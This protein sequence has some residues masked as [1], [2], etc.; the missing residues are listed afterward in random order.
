MRR[1]SGVDSAFIYGETPTWHMH[2][3]S[4]II[5]D[6][7]DMEDGFDVERLK[8]QLVERLPQ[9][10]Q[11]RWKLVEVPFHLDRPGWIEDADF[12]ID[13]HVR[14]I[15]VP[16]PG[17]SD[18]L[19]RLVGDLASYQ[20]DRSRPLWELWVIEGV[21]DGMVAIFAKI[22]HAII[23]GASG[24]GLS[25]ILLDLEPDPP[26]RDLVERGNVGTH[27]PHPLDLMARGMLSF[28]V[29]PWRFGRLAGQLVRQGIEVARAAS[30]PERTLPPM[31]I[32]T[33]RTPLN[34][35]I[36]PHRRFATSTVP[37]DD[38]KAMKNAFGVK[39]NDVVLEL[40]AAA[41]RRWLIDQDELPDDPLIAQVP[42]SLRSEGDDE[43]GTKVGA[44]FTSLATDIED[45]GERLL[46]IHAATQSAKE[47][48]EAM[49]VHKIMGLTEAA[50]PRMIS[51]ASRMYSLAQL[52]RNAPPPMNVIVSNVPGPPFELYMAGAKL[53]GMFPLGPLLYGNRL[54]ITVISFMGRLDFGFMADRD[55]APDPR[56]FA[57]FIP[58]AMRNLEKAAGRRQAAEKRKKKASKK[59]SKA[60][61]DAAEKKSGPKKDKAAAKADE[62]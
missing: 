2:V 3:C 26:Q 40:C 1:L 23:D 27:A 31:G 54:E 60:K 24:A 36:G 4:L 12:D 10:P 45:P 50:P 43:V 46:A 8:R 29:T 20:L 28:A 49:A 7:S 42:V 11:F 35:E 53:K 62:T 33:P 21:E 18:E 58:E 61:K 16:S 56:V 59:K 6:P 48:R 57:D 30:N 13:Y 55:N 5:A 34:G 25:E 37:L 41:I 14:R 39:L 19:N 22:H 51:L 52:D 47:M 15:A 38:V 32:G 9:V 44:M 17:G